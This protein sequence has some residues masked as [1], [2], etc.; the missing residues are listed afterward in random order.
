MIYKIYKKI[1]YLIINNKIP[2]AYEMRAACK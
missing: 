1:K 2:F